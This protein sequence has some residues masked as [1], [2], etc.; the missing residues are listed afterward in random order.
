MIKSYIP[1]CV[2]EASNAAPFPL[3]RLLYAPFPLPV[4]IDGVNLCIRSPVQ[5]LYG[6]QTPGGLTIDQTDHKPDRLGDRGES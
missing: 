1:N 3:Q 2:F 4:L 5:F 6:T